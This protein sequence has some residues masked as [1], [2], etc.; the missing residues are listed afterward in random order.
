[1]PGAEL[2]FFSQDGAPQTFNFGRN[3]GD[4]LVQCVRSCTGRSRFTQG[5]Q[6]AAATHGVVPLINKH[7]DVVTSHLAGV[8]LPR[9]L[10]PDSHA[11]EHA[12][13]RAEQANVARAPRA[14]ESGLCNID[15]NR[16][17]QDGLRVCRPLSPLTS[18]RAAV[19]KLYAFD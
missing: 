19:S 11:P 8:W 18:G 6:V 12:N 7:L 3:L 16:D 17:K 14:S 1:M 2:A 13:Q 10:P 15:R 9:A 5:L 4:L